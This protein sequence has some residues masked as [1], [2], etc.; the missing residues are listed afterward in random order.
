MAY[1]S[2]I[3]FAIIMFYIIAIKFKDSNNNIHQVKYF[4]DFSYY[5]AH[6]YLK[7]HIM[8]LQLAS[9][10]LLDTEQ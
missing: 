10:D 4:S 6:N 2:G 5:F 7:L 1:K 8:N 3:K 9:K